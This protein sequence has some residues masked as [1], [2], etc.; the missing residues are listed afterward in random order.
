M[1]KSI[2][3]LFSIC[4]IAVSCGKDK[5]TTVDPVADKPYSNTN[6]GTNW[7]Y[8]QKTQNPTT[9][10]T[11]FVIDTARVT[12]TDTTVVQGTST[13]IYKIISHTAGVNAYLNVSGNDYYQFQQVAALG[14]QIPEPEDA[15]L[16]MLQ[17]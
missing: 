4:L 7:T 17:R 10:D 1:K 14:T 12:G 11:T 3:A 16:P 5:N 13:R 8:D 2:F 9:G 15:A 6:A